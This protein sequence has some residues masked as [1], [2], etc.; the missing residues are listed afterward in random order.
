MA[1]T[2]GSPEKTIKNRGVSSVCGDTPMLFYACK[3]SEPGNILPADD[4]KNG[5]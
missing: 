1:T 2:L 3:T 5:K 4:T